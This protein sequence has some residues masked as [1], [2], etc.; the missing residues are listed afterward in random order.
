M[1]IMLMMTVTGSVSYA[2]PVAM[3]YLLQRYYIFKN[4]SHPAFLHSY[5]L[6]FSSKYDTRAGGGLVF[7]AATTLIGLLCELPSV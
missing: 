1:L 3:A 6:K 4:S 2:A 7:T 5:K